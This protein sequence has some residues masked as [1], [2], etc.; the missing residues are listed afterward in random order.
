MYVKVG[1]T[2]KTAEQI[3]AE[4]KSELATKDDTALMVIM[5]GIEIKHSQDGADYP[6]LDY[7]IYQEC[8]RLL[9]AMGKEIQ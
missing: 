4:F 6:D 5:K 9:K 7:E 1:P 3:R 2:G 8:K